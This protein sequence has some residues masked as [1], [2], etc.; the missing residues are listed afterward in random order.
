MKRLLCIFFKADF[1]LFLCMLLASP[2]LF[3]INP[4][5]PSGSGQ[6]P[7]VLQGVLLSGN[8]DSS[9]AI[10]LD[11]GSGEAVILKVGDRFRGMELVAVYTN[12]VEL[13]KGERIFSCYLGRDR[14]EPKQEKTGRNNARNQL[15][16]QSEPAAELPLKPN[17]EKETIRREFNRSEME[18]RLQKEWA[19][20]MQET[21]FIPNT[22]DGSIVGFKLTRLPN[23]S[24]LS[25]IGLRRNDIVKEING[26][27][28]N[29][30]SHLFELYQR[31]RNDTRF[32]V[33]VE[34]KNKDLVYEYILK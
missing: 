22:V 28:L 4:Q 17:E 2:V 27:V 21:R 23:R 3:G 26:V 20:I 13:R 31:L 15:A 24:I 7:L 34:R 5:G 10:L 1:F 6:F 33:L 18:A 32:M 16:S 14:W 25:D 9:V 11:S 12:R 30:V 8:A 19:Q 29:D